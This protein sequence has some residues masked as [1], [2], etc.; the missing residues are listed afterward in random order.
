MSTK[1]SVSTMLESGAGRPP[2]SKRSGWRHMRSASL[3]RAIEVLALAAR[4]R[5]AAR[6]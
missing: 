5:A 4:E 3:M 6:G 2:F 1:S